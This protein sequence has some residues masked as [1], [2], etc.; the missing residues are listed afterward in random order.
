MHNKYLQTGAILSLPSLTAC[1]QY[2]KSVC[3]LVKIMQHVSSLHTV[4]SKFNV[5]DFIKEF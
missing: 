5:A 3:R 1:F 4:C 2:V